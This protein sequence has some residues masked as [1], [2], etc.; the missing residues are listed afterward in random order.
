[1]PFRRGEKSND[2]RVGRNN[3]GQPALFASYSGK[4]YGV[5]LILDGIN[6][7]FNLGKQDNLI[8]DNLEVRDVTITGDLNIARV[9]RLDSTEDLAHEAAAS[10]DKTV[11]YFTTSGAETATLAASIKD[12]QIKVFYMAGDGGNMVITVTNP[13]WGGSG[14]LTFADVY[15][16]VVLMYFNS[17]WNIISNVGSVATG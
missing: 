1:M 14:T 17:K 8:I 9:L 7:R 11:S 6:P 15:D 3:I 13:A 2:I 4:V 16:C 5:P 12:G 10:L